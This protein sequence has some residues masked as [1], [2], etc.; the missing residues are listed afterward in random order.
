LPQN[1]KSSAPERETA[2]WQPIAGIDTSRQ[3][4]DSKIMENPKA[5]E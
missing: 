3:D 4:W 1:L 5:N 2:K